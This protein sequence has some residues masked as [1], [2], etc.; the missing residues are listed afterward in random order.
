MCIFG[1]FIIIQYVVLLMCSP[2]LYVLWW[3]RRRRRLRRIRIWITPLLSFLHFVVEFR[4][5]VYFLSLAKLCLCRC[6]CSFMADVHQNNRY[7][8]HSKRKQHA[9]PRK[10]FLCQWHIIHFRHEPF[11]CICWRAP[12]NAAS[13]AI[14]I[15]HTHVVCPHITNRYRYIFYKAFNTGWIRAYIGCL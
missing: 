11:G 13:S 9:Y 10:N 5:V 7:N 12:L 1:W 14:L 15:H 3:F 8:K 6:G 2:S 4:Y